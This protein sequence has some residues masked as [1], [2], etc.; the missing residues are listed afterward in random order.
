MA[1]S[2]RLTEGELQEHFG[3][4]RP[5]EPSHRLRDW[6]AGGHELEEIEKQRL[7]SLSERLLRH[8]SYWN[9][10]TLKMRFLAPLLEM[11][12]YEQGDA[13]GFFEVELKAEVAGQQL[14]TIVDFVVARAK[15]DLIKAPYFCFHEYKREKQPEDPTAQVLLAM[16]IAQAQNPAPIPIY[17]CYVMG[18]NWFFLILEGQTYTVSNLYNASEYEDLVQILRILRKFEGILK[19]ELL[20]TPP[21]A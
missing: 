17:G 20:P 9:E 21:N 7:Q 18:R 6:L 3:L 19:E 10:E 14:K 15:A 5:F 12:D 11:V 16:L 13:Q 2:R 1:I 4:E 8:V